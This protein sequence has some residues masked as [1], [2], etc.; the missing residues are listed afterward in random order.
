MD[1][2]LSLSQDVESKLSLH[3]KNDN[4]TKKESSSSSSNITTTLQQELEHAKLSI[5]SLIS[6]LGYYTWNPSGPYQRLYNVTA[7]A[8][9]QQIDYEGTPS[10][11]VEVGLLQPQFPL[12]F[13]KNLK[14]QSKNN[15]YPYDKPFLIPLHV[16]VKTGRVPSI[17]EFD[18]L[19]GG[20][21]LHMLAT[22]KVDVDDEYYAQLVPGTNIVVVKKHKQ[23]RKNLADI[24]FQFER[25]VTGGTFATTGDNYNNKSKSKSSSGG[26]GLLFE[27][28][29]HLQAMTIGREGERASRVLFAAECD[30]V[31]TD[32]SPV[33]VK[34]MTLSSAHNSAQKFLKT[35]FQMISSGSLSLYRGHHNKGTLTGVNVL[36]L[37][38]VAGMAVSSHHNKNGFQPYEENILKGLAALREAVDAGMFTTGRIMTLSFDKK[39]GSLQVTPLSLF[40]DDS[41]VQELLLLETARSAADG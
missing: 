15:Q 29:H 12:Q 28:A 19:F 5:F 10:H 23:Y 14:P 35:C 17:H 34:L 32:G 38:Q 30:G 21:T 8:M 16:L 26:G 7:Q 31:D 24:G 41:V 3:N 27:S 1:P 13:R 36:S 22:K 18:F 9:L 2:S 33:E 11:V 40:P 4:K 20:S 39:G 37:S 25:F 6:D